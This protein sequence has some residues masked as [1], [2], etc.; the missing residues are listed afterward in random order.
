MSRGKQHLE[1]QVRSVLN[2]VLTQVERDA[3]RTERGA[4]R[5]V[6]A[7]LGV[8]MR[9]VLWRAHEQPHAAPG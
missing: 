2:R 5:E 8:M 6:N 3:E 1:Q 7:L 4:A 9:Q